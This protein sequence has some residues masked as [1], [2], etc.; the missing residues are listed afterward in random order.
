MNRRQF[1]TTLGS[2]LT[3]AIWPTLARVT[4]AQDRPV[5]VEGKAAWIAADQM[6]VAPPGGLPVTAALSQVGPD[7]HR[8]ILS[9]HGAVV[10]GTLPHRGSRLLAASGQDVA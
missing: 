1:G 6:A 5:T 10:P 9:G 3:A 2:A 8:E 4:A 7:Q